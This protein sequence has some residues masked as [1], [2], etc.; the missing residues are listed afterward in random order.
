MAEIRG[1][2]DDAIAGVLDRGDYILG[3]EVEEF[4][5]EFASFCDVEH[6]IGVDSGTSGLELALLAYDIGPGDEVIT[7]AN[8][9]VAT[10]LGISHAGATPVLVDMDEATYSMDV[11]LVESAITPATKAI[12]PVHL[13]GQPVDMDPLLDLAK[14][15]GL[16]VI[17]DASQAHGARYN[18]RRIG[19]LADVAVFSLYPAKNLGGVGD[20]G[21]VVTSDAA[22]AAR[23]R[24]LRNY[25]SE[26][27]YV[28]KFRGF[29]RRLDTLQAAVLR[30][31]LR[32]IEKWNQ[33]RRDHAASYTEAL[34]QFSDVLTTPGTRPDSEPV[35]HLYVVRVD[36]RDRFQAHLA[37]L[38]ITTLVHYPIP[39]HLQ[40]AYEDL[41]LDKGAFPVTERCADQIVSLPMYPELDKALIDEVVE[42]VG[43]FFA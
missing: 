12:I 32:H 43:S 29:N 28:H 34:A 3:S 18:G 31:K 26:S 6:G 21:V 2:V 37:D 30:V 4:E 27:K 1:E 33:Q 10:A 11:D 5:Q 14:R 25:G 35:Y 7:V 22:V 13:Y 39:I 15:H 17:E 23:L 40:E 42:G 20:A 19:S 9:F 24:M 16:V 38:G 41:G 8:T 36:E